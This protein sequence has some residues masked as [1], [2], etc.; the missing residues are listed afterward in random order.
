MTPSDS[1]KM[2]EKY[3]ISQLIS[4]GYYLKFDTLYLFILI[5]VAGLILKF[6]SSKLF[7]LSAFLASSSTFGI[8]KGIAVSTPC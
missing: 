8:S 7:D 6:K 5:T 2:R 3:E 1:S 4:N